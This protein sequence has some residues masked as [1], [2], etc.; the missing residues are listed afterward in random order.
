MDGLDVV[1]IYLPLQHF[2]FGIVE[3]ALLD[4][5]VAFHHN[6]LFKFGVVPVLAFGDAG[7]GDVDTH[8]TGIEGMYQ[9]GEAATIVHV[10]LEWEGGLF[11]WQ[12][13]EESAVE[14]LGKTT[15]RY[16]R[17]HEGLGLIGKAL[18]EF[19]NTTKSY[20]VR[21]GAVAIPTIRSW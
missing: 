3:V 9:L 20:M 4:E 2:A 5:A 21:N 7:L 15:C 18:Q 17:D 6:E 14:L 1:T 19:D 16:I 10:H 13:T 12:V 8:L 11:V